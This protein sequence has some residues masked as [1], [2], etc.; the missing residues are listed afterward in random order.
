MRG[1]EGKEKVEGEKEEE[2]E[3]QDLWTETERGVPWSQNAGLEQLRTCQQHT[4]K[5]AS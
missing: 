2:E 4:I 3:E 1:G 5:S